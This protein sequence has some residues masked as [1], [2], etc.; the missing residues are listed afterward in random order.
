MLRLAPGRGG[1]WIAAEDWHCPALWETVVSRQ[2]WPTPLLQAASLPLLPTESLSPAHSLSLRGETAC[3]L[4]TITSAN[5][6]NNSLFPIAA[7]TNN[8]GLSGLKQQKFILLQLQRS[9]V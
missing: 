4:G 7:V 8:H 3:F 6:S 5:Q 2:A 9:E 1:A